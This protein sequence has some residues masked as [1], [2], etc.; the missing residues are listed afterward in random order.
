[1]FTLPLLDVHVYLPSTNSLVVHRL[2]V[3]NLPSVL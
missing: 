3:G 1:M 2:Q